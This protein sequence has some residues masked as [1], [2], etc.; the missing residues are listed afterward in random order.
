MDPSVTRDALERLIGEQSTTLTRLESLLDREHSLLVARDIESL[1][2]AG[3][4]RQTCVAAL[5]KLD[6]ERVGMCRMLGFGADAD[7]MRKL[8]GWCDP[9]G[10]LKTRWNT[11]SDL[12]R[13]CRTLNDRNGALATAQLKTVS[14]RLDALTGG[15]SSRR[16]DTYSPGGAVRQTPTGRLLAAQV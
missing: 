7:G 4:D 14:G 10:R 15:G 2:V 8:L 5:L 9:S 3:R 11:C 13:R 16:K 1:A 6:G 12:T